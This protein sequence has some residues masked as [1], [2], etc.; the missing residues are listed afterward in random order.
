MDDAA[1]L[2]DLYPD[3]DFATL[4]RRAWLARIVID[5]LETV[6]EVDMNGVAI[7]GYSR[8]GKM[9]T[10]AAAF[11]DRISALVAGSTGVGGVNEDRDY[12]E[13]SVSGITFTE[14]VYQYSNVIYYIKQ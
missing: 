6:P 1:I 13:T 8:D 12:S 3:H 7:Y 4:P 2:K 5:Y 9:A 11:D 10:I 14:D